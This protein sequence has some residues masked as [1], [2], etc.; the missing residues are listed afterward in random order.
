MHSAVSLQAAIDC[1]LVAIT[2]IDAIEF[3]LEIS[4]LLQHVLAAP[5]S[6]ATG[7]SKAPFDYQPYTDA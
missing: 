6:S 5:F 7:Y 2:C 1:N 4:Q 3:K